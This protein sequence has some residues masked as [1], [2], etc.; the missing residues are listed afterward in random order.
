VLDNLA[1][2]TAVT[3]ANDKH[4]LGIGVRVHGK[5]GN[6]LLVSKLIPLGGL[7]DIV[8]DEDVAI[9]A[10]LKDEDLRKPVSQFAHRQLQL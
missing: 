10:A 9:V 1:E 3:T 2:D 7:N 8:Q 4:L 5:V 6:H